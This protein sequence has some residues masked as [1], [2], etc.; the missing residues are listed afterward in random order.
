MVIKSIE[1]GS[2]LPAGAATVVTAPYAPRGPIMVGTSD[3]ET[4]IPMLLPEQR[5]AR[6]FVMNEFNP[7]FMVGTRMRAVVQGS[8]Q[9]WMEGNVDGFTFDTNTL[10]LLIELTSGS[11]GGYRGWNLTIAGERG[12]RGAQGIAGPAGQRGPAGG[13]PGPMGPE[14]PRGFT[15]TLQVGTVQATANPS[16]PPHVTITEAP[17]GGGGSAYTDGIINFWLPRGPT[18]PTGATSFG[19]PTGPTGAASTIPGPTGPTGAQGNAGPVGNPGPLPSAADIVAALTAAGVVNPEDY[20]W[21]DGTRPFIAVARGVA[22]AA[23]VRDT[24]FPTTAW[25]MDRVDALNTTLRAWANTQFMLAAGQ[26]LLSSQRS[27]ASAPTNQCVQACWDTARFQGVGMMMGAGSPGVGG[28]GPHVSKLFFIN[29]N[30]AG[31]YAGNTYAFIEPGTGW[32]IDNVLGCDRLS[33]GTNGQINYDLT[34]GGTLYYVNVVQIS[35]ERIKQN[36]RPSTIDALSVLNHLDVVQYDWRFGKFK[37]RHADIGLTAQQV[38]KYIPD[39]VAE[40]PTPDES[41]IKSPL[42]AKTK[43]VDVN[44]LIFYLIRAVQQLSEQIEALKR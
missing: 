24:S 23:T 21:R 31:Q 38:A 19:G 2:L 37:G 29:V 30:S 34:V 44:E 35:D 28:T 22:P 13:D 7:G 5:V 36:I 4:T 6:S 3:T 10:T 43:G 1:P 15:A 20:A 41:F 27:L 39:A 14:G 32:W 8:S 18:G 9:H 26:T 12:E 25:T 33:V 42:P 17:L 16:D 40:V 11:I